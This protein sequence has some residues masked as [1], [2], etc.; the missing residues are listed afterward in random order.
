M[1]KDGSLEKRG[2]NEDL[3]GTLRLGSYDT[4][5]KEGTLAHKIYEKT[6]FKERHRHRYEVNIKY[7]DRLEEKGMILSGL[8][9]DGKL[10][11]IIE[12]NNYFQNNKNIKHPYFIAGQ[13]HPEFNSDPFNPHPM[14]KGLIKSTLKIKFKDIFD[15]KNNL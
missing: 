1:E 12:I 7:K 14:F 15:K 11:E 13:F 6:S 9:P 4:V 2:K 3:G 8:S 5:V 10:P